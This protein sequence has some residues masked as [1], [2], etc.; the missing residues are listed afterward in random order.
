MFSNKS[1]II[2]NVVV[3]LVKLLFHLFNFDKEVYLLHNMIPHFVVHASQ[4]GKKKC[5]MTIQRLSNP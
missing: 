2:V 5:S 1:N 3:G 4:N